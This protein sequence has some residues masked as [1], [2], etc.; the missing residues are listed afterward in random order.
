MGKPANVLHCAVLKAIIFAH[1]V[2]AGIYT[3]FFASAQL[4]ILDIT[5]LKEY[6][7]RRKI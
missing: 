4:E 3:H 5:L 2:I 6:N 7:K 1:F